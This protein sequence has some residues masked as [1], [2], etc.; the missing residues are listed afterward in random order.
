MTSSDISTAD[1]GRRAED[2]ALEHLERHGLELIA[3]NYRCRA[4]EVDLVM[5]HA[6]LV[7]FVEVRSRARQ[8]AFVSPKETVDWRKQRRLAR[9]AAWFLRRR[10]EYWPTGPV[11][12]DVVSV[13]KPNY[14]ARLEWIR[15]AFQVDDSR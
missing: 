2:L 11:R 1:K 8:S 3:R 6:G 13:T 5:E 7:V 4:G 15:N 10:R 14:H 9:V 12:F